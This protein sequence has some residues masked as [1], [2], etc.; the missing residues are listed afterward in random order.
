M[1]AATSKPAPADADE[2]AL[3]DSALS[4]GL[5][6][7]TWSNLKAALISYFQGY[8]GEKLTAARTYY[9]RT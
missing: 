4:F 5:K 9:V 8:F 7:L 2:L 1:H 3:V 6:K